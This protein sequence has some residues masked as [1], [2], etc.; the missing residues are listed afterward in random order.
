MLLLSLLWPL[1]CPNR[2]HAQFMRCI[3]CVFLSWLTSPASLSI[4]IIYITVF[5]LA[6]SVRQFCNDI[7]YLGRDGPH[8]VAFKVA[9]DVTIA[10]GDLSPSGI[11]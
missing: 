3:G 7:L 5:W 11:F 9:V 1:S 2:T 8:Y 6:D 4:H 10:F